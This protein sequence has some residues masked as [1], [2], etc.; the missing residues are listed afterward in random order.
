VTRPAPRLAAVPQSAESRLR[1]LFAEEDDL[2]A[3]L[4]RNAEAQ[5]AARNDYAEAHG[6]LLRPSVASMRK[7]VG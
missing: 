4:A 2:R 5:K 6:L 7:V 3:A 1:A